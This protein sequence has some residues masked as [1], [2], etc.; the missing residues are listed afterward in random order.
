MEERII[1]TEEVR[2]ALQSIR[3]EFDHATMPLRSFRNI[4]TEINLHNAEVA[5]VDVGTVLETL[6]RDCY[7]VMNGALCEE[8]GKLG[9][10][11][12]KMKDGDEV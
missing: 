1:T 5:P 10:D 2:G 6:I 8:A 12:P 4:L 3:D 7:R 11:F 9:F